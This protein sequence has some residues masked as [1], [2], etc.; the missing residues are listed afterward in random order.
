[1]QFHFLVISSK[2]VPEEWGG[3][4]AQYVK[5]TIRTIQR[6]FEI[7]LHVHYAFNLIRC[8]RPREVPC[9]WLFQV[10]NMIRMWAGNSNSNNSTEKVF[11][12]YIMHLT[13]SNSA[14][15]EKFHF[16]VISSGSPCSPLPTTRCHQG[17]S[18]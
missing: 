2:I 12:M 13:S 1:M 10:K 6:N 11:C 17:I 4:G 8:T 16:L 7:V 14:E 9:F 15:Q 3:K 18:T 5:I